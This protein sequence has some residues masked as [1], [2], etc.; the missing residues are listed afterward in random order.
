MILLFLFDRYWV[1]GV[2]GNS[3][4]KKNYDENYFVNSKKENERFVDLGIR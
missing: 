1:R 2:T 3:L 4:K